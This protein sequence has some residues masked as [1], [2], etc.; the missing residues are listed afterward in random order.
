MVDWPKKSEGY[1]L[2]ELKGCISSIL[3]TNTIFVTNFNSLIQFTF[4]FLVF[5]PPHAVGSV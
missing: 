1:I 2:V 5:K 3:V 4:F